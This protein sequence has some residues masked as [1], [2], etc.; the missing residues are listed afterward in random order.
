M[1]RRRAW[2]WILILCVAGTEPARAEPD[3]DKAIW[4]G[5]AAHRIT[6]TDKWEY[7]DFL[8][9]IVDVKKNTDAT[10]IGTV[11]SLLRNKGLADAITQSQ[12]TL[13][14][15]TF[16]LPEV[17]RANRIYDAL[18]EAG[19]L[20]A[21]VSDYLKDSLRAN[22]RDKTFES[23]ILINRLSSTEFHRNSEY[24]LDVLQDVY[25][26]G[27]KYPEFK[28]AFNEVYG[29]Y[30]RA[31]IGDP[32]DRIL[33]N[34]PDFATLE[35]VR[36]LVNDKGEVSIKVDRLRSSLV[37]GLAGQQKQFAEFRDKLQKLDKSQLQQHMDF[38]KLEDW[39][40]ARADLERSEKVQQLQTE[41]LKSGAFILA[42]VLPKTDD[43]RRF[44]ATVNAVID[45]RAAVQQLEKNQQLANDQATS[46]AAAS[47]FTANLVVIGIALVNAYETAHQEP[48]EKV[49]ME[50][51]ISLS[52]Q[53]EAYQEENRSRFDR[54]DFA[55]NAIYREVVQGFSDVLALI[56][57]AGNDVQATRVSLDLL[58]RRM[59]LFER[60]IEDKLDFLMDQTFR[61]K[62]QG[63][64][65]YRAVAGEDL[66]YPAYIDCVSSIRAY[67][68]DAKLPQQSGEWRADLNNNLALA[69]ELREERW[70]EKINTIREMAVA[71]EH[72]NL[73]GRRANPLRWTTAVR[74][75]IA[76]ASA[77]TDHFKR[78][79]QDFLLELDAEGTSTVRDFSYEMV[80]NNPDKILQLYRDL[81]G[82]YSGAVK[83][84]SA[85][86]AVSRERALEA[87]AMPLEDVTSRL[88]GIAVP[89]K[90][91]QEICKR[92][93]K[94]IAK[95]ATGFPVLPVAKTNFNPSPQLTGD[96]TWPPILGAERVW[97][98]VLRKPEFTDLE[99]LGLGALKL[100]YVAFFDR[101]RAVGT[102]SPVEYLYG[103]PCVQ[104]LLYLTGRAGAE[105]L[106]GWTNEICSLPVRFYVHPPTK[107]Y[108]ASFGAN[109]AFDFK[110][111][112]E[113]VPLP[114]GLPSDG[115]AQS[116]P[117]KRPDNPAPT[118][119]DN[120]GNPQSF[121][122]DPKDAKALTKFFTASEMLS[123]QDVSNRVSSV[124]RTIRQTLAGDT[125]SNV[126]ELGS[127]LEQVNGTVLALRGLTSLLFPN[128][129][130]NDDEIRRILFG[131]SGAS[132]NAILSNGS[133]FLTKDIAGLL[134]AEPDSKAN[135]VTLFVD[136]KPFDQAAPARFMRRIEVAIE[137]SKER[138]EV[139]SLIDSEL[140]RLTNLRNL[141]R[142]LSG[143]K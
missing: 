68:L 28:K 93:I 22:T 80:R 83:R 117:A 129:L 112:I 30:L 88:E 128:F 75:Y 60:E 71:Y 97:D 134:I 65:S 111:Y 40:K 67:V 29:R 99:T 139:I 121:S 38:A 58:S 11:T 105:K 77:N 43:A 19:P 2:L 96:E 5:N 21:L 92:P 8:K 34:N 47:V 33:Q 59:D 52:K 82:R 25:A 90:L 39:I 127:A 138:P 124:M 24:L 106:V 142:E 31:D 57:Q 140:A 81:L 78:A 45:L 49:I 14:A 72:F 13:S 136:L 122:Y 123:P 55:T 110:R 70:A 23:S 125:L 85:A 74:M 48:P 107:S 50:A 141:H 103:T 143:V 20:P 56:G 12:S 86:A 76:L 84:F 54:L 131:Y 3:T 37:S 61:S 130:A 137:K 120:S 7:V 36:S 87:L 66:G 132:S 53:I 116:P 17:D 44:T 115:S 94:H 26:L 119:P 63:C 27:D 79:P 6:S 1:I 10:P 35:Y 104:Y 9:F 108:E 42:T 46:A 15:R 118:P 51:L 133:T 98:L 101:A 109:D 4:V 73:Q 16:V 64:L 135:D 102:A 113:K 126:R 18:R 41:G 91:A 32:A 89:D 62:L 100:G 95:T 114:F 69:N